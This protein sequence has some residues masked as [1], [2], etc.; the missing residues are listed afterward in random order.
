[1]VQSL[2]Q[3]KITSAI[4]SAFATGITCYRLWLRRDRYWWDD[5][6][7]FLSMI[8]L[9]LQVASVFMHVPDPR[10]LTH[11][12]NIAAYYIMAATF[13]SIIW[14]ARLAILYSVI[15][16]DPNPRTRMYL[17]RIGIIFIVV[18]MVMIAQLF[19][20]CEPMPEW[21]HELSPQCPLDHQVAICQLV[22]DVFS[23]L[24]L[25]AAPLRLI[26]QMSAV[27]S[28]RRRLMIIFSTSIVTTIVS[29]V[30]AAFIFEDAGIK[31]VIAAI[32][33]DTFSL[34]VC[35]L[36]VVVTAI[37]RKAGKP[38][39]ETDYTKQSTFG[40]KA[41][42]RRTGTM[43]TTATTASDTAMDVTTVNL[44]DFTTNTAITN[45]TL[46]QIE[47]TRTRGDVTDV[48]LPSLT[49]TRADAPPP[50][51]QRSIVWIT[52]EKLQRTGS[53]EDDPK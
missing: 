3:L 45:P 31:V 49:R 39:E 37:M 43:G 29:L 20:V 47:Q 19:W 41:A 46:S 42:T 18:L 2:I 36:P 40:W 16:I 38:E 32:V 34:I 22:T 50:K 25:I 17:H 10:V 6:G 44:R 48:A 14:T 53:N 35:S 33:E 28:T 12:D 8:F 9:F 13:Y 24:L 52:S 51:E 4:C 15:R 27:D 7:A 5:A 11:T 23:D 1:M 26:Q 21:K 30:H